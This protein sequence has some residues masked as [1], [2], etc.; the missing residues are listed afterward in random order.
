MI[1]FLFPRKGP[2]ELLKPRYLYQME[3]THPFAS[4]L[5]AL[6]AVTI[7][8]ENILLNSTIKNVDPAVCCASLVYRNRKEYVYFTSE[9]VLQSKVTHKF[10]FSPFLDLKGRFI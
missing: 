9:N 4:G 7:S 8:G 10:I 1:L 5:L 3:P 6:L 2:L